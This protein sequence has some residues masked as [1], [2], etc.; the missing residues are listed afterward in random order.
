MCYSDHEIYSVHVNIHTVFLGLWKKR[1][2]MHPMTSDNI[3]NQCRFGGIKNRFGLLDFYCF[4]QQQL[5]ISL[6]HFSLYMLFMSLVS[7]Y[8]A[9]DPLLIWTFRVSDW[10]TSLSHSIGLALYKGS[11]KRQYNLSWFP[12][13]A[14]VRFDQISWFYHTTWVL[15]VDTAF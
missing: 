6:D 3:H 10:A 4:W 7:T 8:S 13:S 15:C 12:D 9:T 14:V 2:R 1:L 11:Q 5:L